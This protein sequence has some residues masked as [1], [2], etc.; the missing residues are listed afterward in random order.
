[1]KLPRMADRA[2]IARLRAAGLTYQEIGTRVG[3]TKQRV[4]QILATEESPTWTQ[5]RIEVVGDTVVVSGDTDI[6]V[7]HAAI[8]AALERLNVT[9]ERAG[10]DASAGK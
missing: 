1:M 3:L 4:H 10:E 5:A 7:I 2:R 6:R 8:I 9:I